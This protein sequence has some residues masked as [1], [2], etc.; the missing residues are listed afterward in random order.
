MSERIRVLLVCQ[1]NTAGVKRH[2]ID[3]LSRIDLAAFDVHFVYNLLACDADFPSLVSA[4]GKRGITCTEMPLLNRPDPRRDLPALARLVRII[5]RWRPHV[6]HGHSS[7]GGALG[8]VAALLAGTGAKTA[9]TPN[10]LSIFASRWYFPIEAA[11]APLTTAMVAS[12]AS[13]AE[14]FRRLRFYGGSDI[15]T[16]PLC[17]DPDRVHATAI[18]AP[19]PAE[20]LGIS[21]CGRICPQ[22][23]TLLFFRVALEA[24]RRGLDW[25]FEWIGDYYGSDPESDQCRA[26]L[27]A[28]PEM[29]LEITGWLADPLGRLAGADV[30]LLLSRYESFGFVTAEA[31]LLERPIVATRTTGTV[32]LVTDGESGYIVKDDVADILEKLGR[33]DRDPALRRRFGRAGRARVERDYPLS[34]MIG[35]TEKMY[36][37]LAAQFPDCNPTTAPA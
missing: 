30:F 20:P 15:R 33:L 17:V 2:V 29:N 24:A 31:M 12:S 19:R 27:A 35:L 37:D 7:K 22:K 10:V 4:V 28:H 36:R 16:I 34:R 3:V 9:F 11:L 23:Q 1:S 13:E 5:R 25:R 21:G 32:D 6:V 8:R 26:L 14:D 18:P